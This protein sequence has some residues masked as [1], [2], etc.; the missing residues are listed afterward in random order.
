MRGRAKVGRRSI[1]VE[2]ATDRRQD[3]ISY[4]F[5]ML[6]P[7]Y[8]VDMNSGREFAARIAAFII[9]VILFTNLDLHYL[10]LWIAIF[11]YLD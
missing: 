5:A 11:R 9:V 10:N 6:L 3:V 8:T 2:S 7:F 1:E 4:L